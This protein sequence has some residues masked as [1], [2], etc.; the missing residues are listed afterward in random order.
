LSSYNVKKIFQKNFGEIPKDNEGRT[1][2]IHHID[3]NNTNNDPSNL[4]AISIKEHY[5]IHY[6]QGDFGAC[7]LIARRMNQPK[8]FLS[9]IQKGKKRPGIGGVK[10]GTIPW[11]K[12]LKG[13]KPKLSIEGK[14]RKLEA[15]KRNAK[16]SDETAGLIRERFIQNE[17]VDSTRLG[18]TQRN[19]KKFTYETAFCEKIA[20]EYGV[21]KSYIFRI[22]RGIAK[23]V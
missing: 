16:I 10:K 7:V 6:E 2:E 8:E 20:Q 21:S 15:A 1:F 13:W 4:K 22:I 3:G 11:N 17:Q 23:I 19:G 9:E 14:K 5:K 18:K 12:G